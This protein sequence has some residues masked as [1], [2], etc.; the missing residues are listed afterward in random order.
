[1][2]SAEG[3]PGDRTAACDRTG[4]N[5]RLRPDRRLARTGA[6]RRLRPDRR[7]DRTGAGNRVIGW[8]CRIGS[9]ERGNAAARGWPR[10]RARHGS[11]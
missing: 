3:L 11:G 5:C 6:N 1:M 9:A 8:Q 7:L 10:F 2:H 4:A